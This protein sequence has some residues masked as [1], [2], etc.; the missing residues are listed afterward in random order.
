M[1][2]FEGLMFGKSLHV[3]YFFEFDRGTNWAAKWVMERDYFGSF[4]QSR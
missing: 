2:V 1:D 4:F 3:I